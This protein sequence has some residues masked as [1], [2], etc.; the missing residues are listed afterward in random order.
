MG[1]LSDFIEIF[2]FVD[3]FNTYR[4]AGKDDVENLITILKN[5]KSK[6]SR[7]EAAE[8]LGKIGD[9]RA[10]DLL[11]EKLKDKKL[12]VRWKAAEAL[13]E[14]KD[15]RAVEPLIQVLNDKDEDW[16]ARKSAAEAL[17]KIGDN[18]AVEPLIEALKYSELSLFSDL[19][20]D[21]TRWGAELALGWIGDNRAVEQIG[22]ASCRERV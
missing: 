8:A 7:W 1:V 5:G 13:G 12:L 20:H 9:A 21:Y 15:H 4:S 16:S 3:L 17:G 11:I 2:R 10:V 19:E 18:R 22:R 14:I 6:Y